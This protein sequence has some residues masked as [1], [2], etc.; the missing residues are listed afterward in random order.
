MNKIVSS[1][2]RKTNDG[3]AD[4]KANKRTSKN[5]P[6]SLAEVF[7]QI[8]WLLSQS[9]THKLMFLADLEWSILP[10][11]RLGQFRIFHNKESPMAF[12]SWAK[13]SDVVLDRM[14]N[15]GPRLR[16][17]EWNSGDTVILMDVVTPFGGLEKVVEE[18]NSTV[19]KGGKAIPVADLMGEGKGE[20]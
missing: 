4:S 20:G 2:D 9:R 18:L 7:Q 17:D 12:A 19:F 13:V 8:I 10:P 1:K 16:P 15:V 3:S 14:K 11:Y 6:K 5:T